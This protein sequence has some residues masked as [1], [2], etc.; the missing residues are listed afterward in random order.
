MSRSDTCNRS[1]RPPEADISTF[2]AMNA[3]IVA[4]SR[5]VFS[6][7]RFFSFPS[8]N[9]SECC[10]ECPIS[11]GFFLLCW[12]E[13]EPQPHV[14]CWRC[15]SWSFPSLPLPRAPVL[16]SSSSLWAHRCRSVL[17]PE[18]ELLVSLVVS[19]TLCPANSGCLALPEVQ[20]WVLD[21][22]EGGLC[23]PLETPLGGEPPA[24]PGLLRLFNVSRES[25][26]VL[27]DVQCPEHHCFTFQPA[28]GS[29]LGRL[30][31]CCSS[32]MCTEEASH[33]CC[34]CTDT[35]SPFLNLPGLK[36]SRTAIL[37]S[38]DLIFLH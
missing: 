8:Q 31:C 17:S 23:C 32:V 22:R 25:A 20:P 27:L 16:G 6:D 14:T 10:T 33:P 3:L 26:S 24:I 34:V 30:I 4:G 1:F 2:L 28:C 18:D 37:A 35:Q 13:R 21:P 38:W 9:F 12:V 5:S 15:S 19:L 11:Y 7:S 36:Q 29:S